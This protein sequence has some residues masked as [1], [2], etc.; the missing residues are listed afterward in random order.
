VRDSQLATP[1]DASR[2]NFAEFTFKRGQVRVNPHDFIKGFKR[3]N[4]ASGAASGRSVTV[5][6]EWEGHSF[7]ETVGRSV[8]VKI[9]ED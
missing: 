5:I 8:I 2:S 6:V 4:S 9:K 7:G 1:N 3:K